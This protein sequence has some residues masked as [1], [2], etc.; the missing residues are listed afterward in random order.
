MVPSSP[1]ASL[2]KRKKQRSVKKT[3]WTEDEMN[4]VKIGLS[5][6]VK[7]LKYP[8]KDACETCI[9]EESPALYRRD[10]R[11]VK[12]CAKNII[13]KIKKEK[14]NLILLETNEDTQNNS[15]SGM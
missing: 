11:S 2:K 15:G 1:S 9:D 8:G 12:Y 10:W 5:S 14:K 3:P 4:A 6:Y 7:R 13:D